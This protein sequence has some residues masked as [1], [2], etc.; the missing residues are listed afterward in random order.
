VG[1]EPREGGELPVAGVLVAGPG[2]G[3]QLAPRRAEV[4]AWL[5][6]GGRVLALGLDEAGANAFLPG[7]VAITAREH[8]AAHFAPFGAG[9]VFTGVSPAEVHNRDPRPVPLVASGAAVVGDGVLASAQDGRVVFCQLAPWQFDYA[10]GRMNV[11]RTFRR[12]ACLAARLL[13][14]LG[15]ESATP[16]VERFSKPAGAGEKRWLEGFYLDVPEEWDDP[17]RFFRW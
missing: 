11:K 16:L 2:G 1:L 5:A 12:V 3:E 15:A 10:D 7:K 8:I 9:S 6:A 13:A 14:N 4:G 17:Y